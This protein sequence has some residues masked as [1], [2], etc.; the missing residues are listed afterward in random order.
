M[1]IEYL[2][3][4]VELAQC[5]NFT[6]AARRCNITQPAL[7][8]HLA[9]L[10]RELGAT[11]VNRNRHGAELSQAG[12]A[13]LQDAVPLCEQYRA[14]CARVRSLAAMPTLKIGGLL[15]NPRVLWIVSSALAA[16]DGDQ[17]IS[18]TYDQ[19]MSRP[20]LELLEDGTVD[21]A[22]MYQDE[23]QQVAAGKGFSRLALFSDP[24]VAVV[25]AEN[26][27]ASRDSLTMEDLADQTF[28]RL[29]GPYFSLGWEHLEAVCRAHGFT[30]RCKAAAMQPGLDYSLVNL[31]GCVLVLSQSALTG[32]LFTR[33]KTHRCIPVTSP[34]A[35]FSIC[36][37][38]RADNKNHAL[39]LFLQRIKDTL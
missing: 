13:L 5:L 2:E 24:F 26:P 38:Y 20:F 7:S 34:D 31:D 27:L 11:L 12:H 10:E 30:P 15:Q 4:F 35:A 29:S 14:A 33:T 32:Q 16:H 6:E 21:L 8:K 17:G 28:I 37:V 1:H 19:T 39:R 22:F 18:C 36:A 9:A 23:T 3:E 25:P